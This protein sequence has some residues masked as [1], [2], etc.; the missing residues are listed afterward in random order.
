MGE[1]GDLAEGSAGETTFDGLAGLVDA[2]NAASWSHGSSV[3]RESGDDDGDDSMV[4]G[5][6][7]PTTRAFASTAGLG[8]V[9]GGGT[10]VVGQDTD[11]S[12]AVVGDD[13][14]LSLANGSHDESV[15]KAANKATVCLTGVF[16]TGSGE[17]RSR[18]SKSVVGDGAFMGATV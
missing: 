18:R 9:R 8:T 6:G 7:L 13:D 16:V 15:D 3:L 10:L 5:Q 2:E 12:E 11:W 4:S 17:S 14:V 1:T